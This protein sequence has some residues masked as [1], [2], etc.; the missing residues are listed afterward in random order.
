[1]CTAT[2]TAEISAPAGL[3]AASASQTRYVTC[4]GGSGGEA[5][6]SATLGWSGYT[7]LW[8]N[9]QTGET[10]TGLTAGTYAVTV[11]DAHGCTATATAVVSAPGGQIAASASQTHYVTCLGGSDGEATVTATLGWS[12]YT[13]LWNN[14]QTSQIATGLTAGNYAVTVTDAHGCTVTASVTVTQPNQLTAVASVVSGV[15]CFEGSDGSATV[16]VS[17]GAAPMSYIWSTTPAQHAMTATGLA[18]GTYTVTVTDGH[19]CSATSS[20]TISQSPQWWPGLTGPES[21]CEHSTGNVYTTEGGMSNYQWIVSAGGSITAGGSGADNTVTVTWDSPGGTV[22]VNYTTPGGCAA[23]EP[24]VRHV[25]VTPGP[26]PVISG[27]SNV[28]QGQV[29]TY[30]TPLVAGHTYTWNASH[31]NPVLCFPNTN[32]LTITWD[33]P[34]GIIN[35][36]YVKVTETDQVTGCSTTVTKWITV[37]P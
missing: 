26:A 18:A 29:V 36:G 35:P 34:C 5:T 32:C 30:S 14:S 15:T 25:E 28:V 17:G 13:Y 20:T 9:N 3:L 23:V 27:E 11:T 2:A 31:G 24:T 10:A 33:F 21:V 19:G 8:N 22:T 4:L 16:N 1:G 7:Y 6:V 37:T 12:G